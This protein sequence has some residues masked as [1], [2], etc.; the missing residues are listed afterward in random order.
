MSV[1][2]RGAGR[3]SVGRTTPREEEPVRHGKAF[4]IPKRLV[5][6]SYK[7]VKAS[8]GSAGCDGQTMTKFDED[9]DRNL[10]KLW[11]RLSS[12]SYHPPPVL[13]QEDGL[14]HPASWEY[15]HTTSTPDE[16]TSAFDISPCSP[17]TTV[18]KLSPAAP[19][20]DNNESP[21]H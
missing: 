19:N 10:Y 16:T 17:L 13:R 21:T 20:N 9:R 18:P 4:D 12:G 2:R 1:E 8:R 15:G 11:N 5:W 3:R 14:A 6:E 7:Q